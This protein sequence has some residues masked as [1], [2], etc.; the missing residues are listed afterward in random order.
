MANKKR[1]IFAGLIVCVILIIGL[2]YIFGAKKTPAVTQKIINPYYGVIKT[3]VST[4]GTILPQ[5]RLEIKP[6]IS[7][8]VEKI[9]VKE[10]DHVK[11]GQTLIWMSSTDRAALID[12]ARAQGGAQLKYWEDVYKPIPIIA[13]ITGTVIVRAVEPGQTVT[14][15][16]SI[17]VLSD[18]LI[19]KAN[20]DETDIGRIK[21]GQTAEIS[22]D[23]YPDVK[24]NGRVNLI[25]YESTTINNVTTYEVEIIPDKVPA[26]YK[27]GMSA[28]ISIIDKFKN[29]VLLI[30]DTAIIHEDQQTYVLIGRGK[31]QKPEKRLIK[32]G[33]NDDQHVE[34]LSGL[35]ESEKIIIIQKSFVTTE[36]NNTGSPFMPSRKK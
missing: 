9:L 11:A 8:R 28:N 31:D 14:T 12:A 17:I 29:N 5:N 6:S 27:S 10:G 36:K 30:P 35:S 16:T 33:L 20:V 25:K 18:R 2:I 34:I 4:T 15:T 1:K 23:A 7:G 13:P 26:V 3:A 22:L 19:V 24:V 32:T 21:K